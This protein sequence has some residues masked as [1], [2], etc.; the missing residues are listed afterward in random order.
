MSRKQEN[1]VDSEA[2]CKILSS[3]GTALHDPGYK[4]QGEF[5]GDNIC[6]G[7]QKS[8]ELDPGQPYIFLVYACLT[9]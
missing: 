8:E 4:D 6:E 2:V 7:T 9:F 5:K 1:L 3:Y